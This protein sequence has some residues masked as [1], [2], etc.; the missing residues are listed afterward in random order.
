[1]IL[2][3]IFIQI[4]LEVGRMNKESL[5]S[6][7]CDRIWLQILYM[8]GVGMGV[9]LFLHW[10]DWDLPQ[11]LM[12]LLTIM[13]PL[14]VFEENTYPGGF[15]FMN[16]IGQHSDAPMVYP[17]NRL[18]NM[19]TNLGAEIYFIFLLF[20]AKDLA[21]ISVLVVVLFGLVETFMHT[22][23]GLAIY[24]KYRTKGK[25]TIYA[26][27]NATA[28]TVLFSMSVY[29]IDWLVKNGLSISQ[30]FAGIGLVAF[31]IVGL[32]LLPFSISRKIKSKTFAF[33]DLGYWAKYEQKR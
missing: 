4:I 25:R 14:H 23:D 6:K 9:V 12:G 19:I 8:L 15:Y 33:T 24:K 21:A 20:F 5:L 29:G 16:N 22:K 31:V 32:I 3:E 1:M 7:W 30:F 18:T 10:N 11:R 26:P 27:G 13:V 2:T 17:Q 28:F